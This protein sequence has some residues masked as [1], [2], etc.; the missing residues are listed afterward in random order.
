MRKILSFL[1]LLLLSS[2]F[3]YY[4]NAER[5]AIMGI[6]DND[7]SEKQEF[8]IGKSKNFDLVYLINGD[9]IDIP[10]G[11][12][13]EEN[14]AYVGKRVIKSF[15]QSFCNVAVP[16]SDV[17]GC[18]RTLRGIVDVEIILKNN[19]TKKWTLL[20]KKSIN[21]DAYYRSVLLTQVYLGTDTA[22]YRNRLNFN[23]D[24][25]KMRSIVFDDSKDTL[26]HY[27]GW[28]WD[29]REKYE[30]NLIEDRFFVEIP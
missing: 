9:T 5:L 13:R 20:A 29:K 15:S 24:W 25:S 26:Y 21:M 23:I 8:N 3:S 14:R 7:E 6:V 11:F 12:I 1:L 27:T 22:K 10:L 4:H 18:G 17:F 30:N 28:F 16:A 2:C 19:K